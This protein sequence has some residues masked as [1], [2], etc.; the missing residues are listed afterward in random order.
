MRDAGHE[1]L[2]AIERDLRVAF[3]ERDEASWSTSM[4]R[5]DRVL[6]QHLRE[7]EERVIPCLLA[8]E[9]REFRAYYDGS[10]AT[11][12]RAAACACP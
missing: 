8:L 11:V 4:A 3:A 6:R 2:H 10:A 12:L 1:A 9:P 5:Y 7:E